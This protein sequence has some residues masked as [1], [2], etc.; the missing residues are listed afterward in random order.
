MNRREDYFSRLTFSDGHTKL[1]N[2][3]SELL[4]IYKEFNPLYKTEIYRVCV[5]NCLMTSGFNPSL[6]DSNYIPPLKLLFEQASKFFALPLNM[7]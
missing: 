3:C 5:L 6:M 1:V 4:N 2:L 7:P